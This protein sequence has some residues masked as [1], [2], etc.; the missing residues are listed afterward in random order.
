MSLVKSQTG[1][2]TSH[3]TVIVLYIYIS[4]LGR[5]ASY[6][7]IQACGGEVVSAMMMNIMIP[8][9]NRGLR[10]NLLVTTK[11]FSQPLTTC[12]FSC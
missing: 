6:Y 3:F 2:N 7:N 11:V 5:K 1:S 4:S 8:N 12:V 10:V 9:S